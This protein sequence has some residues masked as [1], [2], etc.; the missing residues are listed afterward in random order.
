MLENWYRRKFP[1]GQSAFPTKADNW[2]AILTL[3]IWLCISILVG[4]LTALKYG[5]GP[6]Q[7][8]LF[9]KNLLIFFWGAGFV[10]CFLVLL[11]MAVAFW[12]VLSSE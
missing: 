9:F 4:L 12:Q 8:V 5:Q 10:A 2:E 11:L 1:R 3:F 7:L 6:E